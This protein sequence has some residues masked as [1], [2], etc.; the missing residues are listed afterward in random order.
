VQ[1]CFHIQQHF[2]YII[3][4]EQSVLSDSDS[5]GERSSIL[6]SHCNPQRVVVQFHQPDSVSTPPKKTAAP[7]IAGTRPI[8]ATAATHQI[9][10][11][12]THNSD[13]SSSATMQCAQRL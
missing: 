3:K 12:A 7:K 6:R 1:F 2:T 5:T 8:W 4:E 10:P 9:S 13:S 11:T